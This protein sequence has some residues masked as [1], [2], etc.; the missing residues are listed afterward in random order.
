MS[1]LRRLLLAIL[2]VPAIFPQGVLERAHVAVPEDERRAIED[3]RRGAKPRLF[4]TRKAP[5]D[6]SENERA[7]A[8]S[9]VKNSVVLISAPGTSIYGLSIE[10]QYLGSGVVWD[11]SGHV[12][13]NHHLVSS[14]GE[15]E[16]EM[17]SETLSLQVHTLDGTE[18]EAI[19]VGSAPEFDL[20]LLRVEGGIKGAKPIP[21]ACS[22]ELVVGQSVLAIGNPF[23][24]GHSLSSG[25]ISALGR[26]IPFPDGPSIIG[27]IQTD[28]AINQGNS[29][30]PLLNSR[31]Q[32]V[33]INAAMLSPS[34]WSAGLGYAIPSEL[35]IRELSRLLEK[36]RAA[37]PPM[38]LEPFEIASS[39][40]FE[41]AKR[42]VVGVH[43]L[44]RYREIWT[45]NEVLDPIGS[46]SGV[47]WD[48]EGHI[49]TSFHVIALRDSLTGSV[50]VADIIVITTSDG[51]NAIAQVVK[52]FPDIDLA[53][54]KLDQT[55]EGL[56]PIQLGSA[57]GLKIGQPVLALGNPFGNRQSLTSGI[58]SALN[59]TIESP[60]NK[61][62]SG[63]IQTDATINPGNSGGPLLDI[64]GRML[65]IN[66][67]IMSNTG[68]SAK[69]GFAIPTGLIRK[70]LEG[71]A[72][73]A[74]TPKEPPLPPSLE[75]KNR[76]AIFNKAKNSVVYIHSETAKFDV[77]DTWT[78]NIF[79]LPPAS[80]T[81]IIWDEKG[82]IVTSYSTLLA[83]DPL[84]GHISE[85]ERL[86]VTLADGNT[87]RA[88]IIGRSLE[89]RI[90]V[91]RVFAPF[92][93]MRPLP[94]A[95]LEGLKVGQSLYAI[96]NPFG[97][98]YSLSAGI[99]SAERDMGGSFRGMLQTDAAIN[100]GNIGGAI[101]DSA[102]SLAGMGIFIEGPGSHSGINFAL[103]STTLNRVVPILLAKGQ[104]E[105]PALGF[106]SVGPIE[107]R[108]FFN[109]EKGVLVQSVDIGSLAAKAGL[110]G[111]QPSKAG[112]G[113]DIGDIIVGLRGKPVNNSEALWDLIEQEPA[114][115]QLP[116]DVLRDGKRIKVVVKP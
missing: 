75:E 32:M 46:G 65:G 57:V 4:T 78:G 105:R 48:N 19:L 10:G 1:H 94:L 62:I 38:P 79:R 116:F 109:V 42:S 58:I 51:K 89:Y 103:S 25:V 2:L 15:H 39:V 96:G 45:G 93:D 91:L 87:Y 16:G 97:M 18:Y 98:D 27:A 50:R 7:K 84:T 81:G 47:L 21:L 63:V 8:F 17:L 44:E 11:E 64:N 31:G 77:R 74:A 24:Y 90:A 111:L 55:P 92:K 100:P 9:N 95:R 34:G 59:R 71:I 104:V 108:R 88:R 33:G 102:G 30:G 82:H 110:R 5:F 72:G 67:M 83:T 113:Y 52:V 73:T 53:L 114:G 56:E 70:A 37:E 101:L 40:A 43:T 66:A 35:V 23:G 86:T 112:R 13:T 26:T 3:A 14:V 54:L 60:S 6:A 22:S 85:A 69:V 20:A 115:A 76:E 99:L 28:A 80:G 106:V 36:P 12:V 107:A 68:A 41:K 49:V 61:P 29:G